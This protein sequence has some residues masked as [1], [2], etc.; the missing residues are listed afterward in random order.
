MNI[1][2]D[3]VKLLDKHISCDS[4]LLY[5]VI[6]FNKCDYILHL[7]TIGMIGFVHSYRF[8]DSTFEHQWTSVF[9][10]NLPIPLLGLNTQP[11]NRLFSWPCRMK[12]ISVV[13]LHNVGRSLLMSIC[14]DSTFLHN[15]YKNVMWIYT[16]ISHQFILMYNGYIQIIIVP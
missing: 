2:K 1:F 10:I 9:M 4:L 11:T 16:I 13:S 12:L 15:L 14:I 7:R 3:T 5:I 6:C 8:R